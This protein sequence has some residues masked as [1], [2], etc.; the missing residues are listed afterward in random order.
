[1]KWRIVARKD[2]AILHDAVTLVEL[3][4]RLA[5]DVLASANAECAVY[6]NIELQVLRVGRR[7]YEPLLQAVGAHVISWGPS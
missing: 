1:V 7:R 4:A 6:D 5:F 3:E 2:G